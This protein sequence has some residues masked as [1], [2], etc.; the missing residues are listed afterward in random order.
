MRQSVDNKPEEGASTR[1]GCGLKM[2]SHVHADG[3][4]SCGGAQ[5]FGFL[6]GLCGSLRAFDACSLQSPCLKYSLCQNYE[7]E[8]TC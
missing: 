1:L 3:R 8:K 2:D 7:Y 5:Q 6:D 4:I